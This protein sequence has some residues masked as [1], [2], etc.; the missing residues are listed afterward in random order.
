MASVKR[1]PDK[2]DYASPTQFRFGIH[3]LP[4]VEFFSTAATIPAIAL[5]DVIVPTA[6]KSIP[7]MGDQLTY[8]NLSIS[9]IVD[10]YL[11][12]YLSIHEW[13]T[14]IGFPKNRTQFSQFKSNTS[15]TPS[16]AS[17]PSRDIGDVQKPTSANALFSDATLTVLSNKNNPIVNVF[18]RDLYPIA[19]TGLSYNQAAT[20]VEYLTAEI[21]FAYQL[22]EIE[23]IS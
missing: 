12:N 20:D 23:T 5:S 2:L 8:D 4:K 15:N 19:M 3:Q 22:Y 17:S 11:E 14:A 18:F 9:F 13:M 1:Q 6:F 10:E 7:M 16:T 21:T